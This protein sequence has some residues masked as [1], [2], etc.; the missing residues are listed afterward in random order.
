MKEHRRTGF[1]MVLGL[2]F[3]TCCVGSVAAA[4][5][6]QKE[7]AYM[8]ATLQIELFKR[9]DI[10]P[11]DVLKAQK[12]EYDRTEEKVNAVTV[13][14]W[15]N[16]MKMAE[17]S[18]KRYQDGTYRELEGITVGIKD[19][20]HDAGW[21]VTQG[22][23]IHKNDPPKKEADPIV[24]KLKDAGAIPVLQTTAPEFY[25]NFTTATK[26]WG[27]SRNPWNLKY[28]VGG[29]SGGSG[30]A[31]AAGYVTLAT[32]SDMGG[33]IRIPCAF[34]GLYG[35]KP[36][37]GYIHTEL[38]LSHFSGTGPMARNFQD[39]VKMYNVITGPGKDSVNVATAVKFPLD[40]ESITGMK[41]AYLGGMGVVEPT[42]EV[43][44]AMQNAIKVLKTQGAQVD[45]LKFDFEL[46]EPLFVTFKKVVLAGSMGGMFAGYGDDLDKMTPYARHFIEASVSG[47]FGNKDALAA[48]NILRQL[49]A[50]LADEVYAKGYDII[51]VPT[52]PTSHV[53]ADYDFTVDEAL[54]ED[55]REFPKSL[56][57]QYTLPFNFMN[58]NPVVSVP[59]G[60]SS[61]GMPIG[62]QIV[63]KP[64]DTETA[65]RV[66]YAYSKGGPKLYTG[67]LFPKAE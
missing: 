4:E 6:T 1:M 24:T 54:V 36:A 59:A 7:L 67:K 44:A 15:D 47:E 57:A 17:E 40:Y 45:T 11:M 25:V 9:G 27:I 38:P 56:G 64:H 61:Q 20:H 49:Y 2:I 39:M 41:I 34:D 63:G 8:P 21:V 19:E 29:S 5:F 52:L 3:L 43:A 58:W 26:A 10:S 55:G 35:M 42:K 50:K 33:S 14:Y 48:E 18:A 46:A 53:P 13:A 65:L 22:S 23:L 16:A 66:A 31:L 51:I 28:A 37:F 60:I 12:A 30:A 32:G 62:M